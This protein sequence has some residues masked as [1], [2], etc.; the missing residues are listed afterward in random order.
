MAVVLARYLNSDRLSCI[1]CNTK[2]SYI[3]VSTSFSSLTSTMQCAL[4]H[5]TKRF[6]TLSK[7][8]PIHVKYT[9]SMND[10]IPAPLRVMDDAHAF[11]RS[12]LIHTA[13]KLQI[14]DFINDEAKSVSDIAKHTETENVDQ[15]ERL[16]YALASIGYFELRKERVFANNDMSSCLRRN[17]PVSIAGMI[18]HLAEDCY[19]AWGKLPQMFGPDPIECPWD[20]AN[21]KYAAGKDRGGFFGPGGYTESEPAQEE[22][23]MRAMSSLETLGGDAMAKGGPFQKFK[24]ILDIG[25]SQGHFLFRLLETYPDKTGMLMDRP[26]V[27][28][29][30]QGTNAKN[31]ELNSMEYFGG[32]FFDQDKMP[33]VEDGDVLMLRYVLHNWSDEDVLKILKTLRA[34]IGDK[35]A[36]VLIGENAMLDRDRISVPSLVHQID[37]HMMTI[38]GQAKGRTPKQWHDILEDGGFNMES[39]HST[40][41]LLHWVECSP[42]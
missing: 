34:C 35:V 12:M 14:A 40:E 11:Q 20:E 22:Q 25:G 8:N 17:N 4:R 9:N 32:D 41:S 42:K 18:G 36:S 10:S 2:L 23:F 13:Q 21:P 27:I 7:R 15:I 6:S 31:E 3:S 24:R 26:A 39:I 29:L 28:E 37:I 33:E 1:R 30:V 5:A 16:M 19:A 38:Y